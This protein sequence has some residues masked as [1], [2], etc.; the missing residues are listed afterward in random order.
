MLKPDCF[1]TLQG[2]QQALNQITGNACLHIRHA[3]AR[4]SHKASISSETDVINY[5]ALNLNTEQVSNLRSI[6]GLVSSL[7]IAG[8]IVTINTLLLQ[9]A[10]HKLKLTI[11]MSKEGL[12]NP[13]FFVNYT[14]NKTQLPRLTRRGQRVVTMTPA[15]SEHLPFEPTVYAKR[16]S[17]A[18]RS[19]TD[20]AALQTQSSQQTTL[21]FPRLEKYLIECILE[22]LIP[23]WDNYQQTLRKMRLFSNK[24]AEIDTVKT[25]WP[26]DFI[27]IQQSIS[28]GRHTV[29]RQFER[30]PQKWTF[31]GVVSVERSVD[32]RLTSFFSP[33][34]CLSPH[35][36]QYLLEHCNQRDLM[37]M[38]T[39]P[40]NH[41]SRVLGLS[42]IS[43][44]E[45]VDINVVSPRQ[46]QLT[47]TSTFSMVNTAPCA[48]NQY[49]DSPQYRY[50]HHSDKTSKKE[51][52][53][54]ASPF[55]VII[56]FTL[57]VTD[58][59]VAFITRP[60]FEYVNF[61]QIDLLG[62]SLFPVV[63]YL[64]LI[65]YDIEHETNPSE[66]LC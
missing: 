66:S 47:L 5:T 49:Q 48:L 53:D 28:D 16:R 11:N 65:M 61:E 44:K 54:V 39:W 35:M 36:K 55:Y 50:R 34:I 26:R 60:E 18:T 14:T 12:S 22:P 4:H 27:R 63:T 64:K 10:T 7:N 41:M 31:Y 56:K 15:A 30:V 45:E 8:T 32:D 9:Y 38:F 58:I 21:P 20:T 57:T 23:F 37:G 29:K 17:L 6:A 51:S 3:S 19:L 40:K 25:D 42:P 52:L 59:N 24:H 46:V 2:I 62:R 33:P 13:H 1:A 43:S